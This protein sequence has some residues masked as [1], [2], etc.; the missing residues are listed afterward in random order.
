MAAIVKVFRT[1][2]SALDRFQDSVAQAV[3]ALGQ[4][5]V[6][7]GTLLA[8]VQ[9]G[10]VTTQVAHTLGRPLRGWMVVDRTGDV[11]VW[12]DVANDNTPSLTLP[13]VANG[14]ATVSLWVF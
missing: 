12:R 2:N 6:E 9:V 5:V 3:N 14:S 4:P 13:L 11:R 8:G 1:G 10:T 7:G